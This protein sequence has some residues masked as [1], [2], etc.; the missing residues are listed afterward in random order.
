MLSKIKL[1]YGLDLLCFYAYCLS[2][3]KVFAIKQV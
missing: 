2:L 1:Q 3:I